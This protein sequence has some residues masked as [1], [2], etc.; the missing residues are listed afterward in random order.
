M[1][2]DVLSLESEWQ[3]VSSGPQD[4]SQYLTDISNGHDLSST[5]WEFFT[6][7][8]ISGL[9]QESEWQQVS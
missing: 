4:S 9:L 1:W 7:G 6:P 5:P 2:A 8:L 3:Q